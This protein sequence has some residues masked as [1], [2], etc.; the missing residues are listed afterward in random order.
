MSATEQGTALPLSEAAARFGITPDALRM[1]LRRGKVRGFKRDGR[2]FVYAD[3]QANAASEP[4]DDRFGSEDGPGPGPSQ[5]GL[6]AARPARDRDLGVVVEFQKVEL[7]RVLR[8]NERL[9]RRVDEL[10]EEL[11]H[12]REVQQREQI[13]RQQDQTLRAQAQNILEQLVGRLGL[14]APSGAPA[15]EGDRAATPPST[16]PSTTPSSA[17]PAEDDRAAAPPPAGRAATQ[18][19]SRPAARPTASPEGAETAPGAPPPGGAAP[20]AEAPSTPA[21]AATREP[22]QK[23]PAWP[24]P[25][26]PLGTEDAAALAD[27]LREVGESLREPASPVQS[28]PGPAVAGERRPP[29]R[30]APVQDR[31]TREPQSDVTPWR[32]SSV[33]DLESPP[34]EEERRNAAR[35]MRRL[36]RNRRDPGEGEP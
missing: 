9:N 24:P 35:I 18:P 27:I 11:R 14:P 30:G 19:A 16:A 4:P 32:G 23:T 26:P 21:T 15:E 29:G 36:F 5:G 13:L 3:A 22:A 28:S 8:E 2:L 31:P 7:D 10:L 6:A 25:R 34:S 12:L 20:V 1:R 33:A 17:R